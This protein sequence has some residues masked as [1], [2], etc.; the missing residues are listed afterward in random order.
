MKFRFLSGVI[1][2]VFELPFQGENTMNV[3]FQSRGVA[4]GRNNLSFQDVNVFI[5]SDF[6]N[7]F[8]S[9]FL[10]LLYVVLNM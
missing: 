10:I 6:L 3:Y 9:H 1:L 2:L 5:L 7:T 4:L 8:T